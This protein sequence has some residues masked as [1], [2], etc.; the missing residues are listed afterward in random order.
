MGGSVLSFFNAEWK[1]S[2]SGLSLYF[3]FYNSLF[4]WSSPEP[5]GKEWY[6][7]QF[8]SIIVVIV[9]CKLWH[10]NLLWNYWVNWYQSWCGCSLNAPLQIL[11]FSINQ[12]SSTEKRPRW[13]KKGCFFFFCLFYCAILH[14]LCFISLQNKLNIQRRTEI[15]TEDRGGLFFLK[16]YIYRISVFFSRVPNFRIIRDSHRSA[17]KRTRVNFL[18]SVH[19]FFLNFLK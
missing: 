2:D 8:T 11:C 5:K 14:V 7:H 19:K 15:E 16:R 17:K 6:C 3:N 1:V 18:P 12:K 10:F 9:I 13:C 4:F